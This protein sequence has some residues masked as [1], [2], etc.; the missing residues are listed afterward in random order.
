MLLPT[1]SSIQA[2]TN[3]KRLTEA[4]DVNDDKTGFGSVTV[5]VL[6]VYCSVMRCLRAQCSLIYS[7]ISYFWHTSH[8]QL[9]VAPVMYNETQTF[10]YKLHNDAC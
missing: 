3:S 1:L 2:L 10:A 5:V 4:K 7:Y 6:D 9:A 8:Y